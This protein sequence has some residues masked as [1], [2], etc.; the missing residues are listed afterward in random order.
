MKIKNQILS[1]IFI[2][3]IALITF[4]CSQDDEPQVVKL[5]NIVEIASANA[6]LSILVAALKKTSLDVTLKTAG[7]YTVFAPTNTAFT[8]AGYTEA[9]IVALDPLVPA[10]V[11]T[12][13]TLKKVLQYH[14][15]SIGTRSSDLLEVGYSKTFAAGIST[16]TNG[17]LSM[18]VNKVGTDVLINGG[19]TNGGSKVETADIDASNGVIHIINNVLALPKIVNHVIANPKLSTLLTTVTSTPQA[20]VLAVL[21]G[22]GTTTTTAITVYAPSNDAFTAASFIVGASDA[23]VTKV[24]Q[25]HLETG[26]RIPVVAGTSFATTD[27]LVS[28]RLVSPTL[29]RFTIAKSTVKLVDQALNASFIKNIN[30]QGTNGVVHIIDKVLVPVL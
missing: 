20:S 24:L 29:Q 4:S 18:F 13:N 19:S 14:V 2:A 15:L 1:F 30:V 25:Y 28:T 11:T 16:A 8:T 27:I 23:N 3:S 7:S 12:I 5:K 26:N 21:N 22:A 10:D 17:S 6:D 9:G